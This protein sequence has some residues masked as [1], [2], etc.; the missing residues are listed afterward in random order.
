M[1][2][3][4]TTA[5]AV[6]GSSPLPQ[7]PCCKPLRS[8]LDGGPCFFSGILCRNLAILAQL[9]P[10]RGLVQQW[11][12]AEQPPTSLWVPWLPVGLGSVSQGG[13][14][15]SRPPPA[16]FTPSSGPALAVC[17]AVYTA[18]PCAFRAWSPELRDE[19][20]LVAGLLFQPQPVRLW[21]PCSSSPAL[22]PREAPSN[23]FWCSCTG[24][25][26]VFVQTSVDG[27]CSPPLQRR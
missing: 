14:D 11:E 26:H 6:G 12:S 1:R 9:E 20:A 18:A 5:P 8:I 2:D 17:R 25:C 21:S 16:S 22:R 27:L 24:V 4:R 13:W 19:P 10:D 23:C 3:G 15:R 7:T